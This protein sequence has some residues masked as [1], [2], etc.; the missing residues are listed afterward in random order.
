MLIHIHG[1]GLPGRVRAG[2][3]T[4]PGYGNVH[5]GVQRRDRTREIMGIVP[6]DAPAALWTI[7]CQAVEAPMDAVDIRGPYVHGRPGARFVYLS[8]GTVDDAGAFTMFQR[9]KLMFDAVPPAVARAALASG[10]L[11][12]RLCLT[13]AKGLPLCAAVRPPLVTWSTEPEIRFRGV[14]V[15]GR[16]PGRRARGPG[17]P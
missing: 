6:G 11:H 14:P 16:V 1:T 5:V 4:S 13:D 15:S 17:A 8:W 3:G 12:A 9:A 2:D 7:E 10:S